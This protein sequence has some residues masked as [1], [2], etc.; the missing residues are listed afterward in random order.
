MKGE[1]GCLA[2]EAR[3]RGQ[4]PVRVSVEREVRSIKQTTTT[5]QTRSSPRAHD[6]TDR[7]RRRRLSPPN[8]TRSAGRAHARPRR[9]SKAA[10][11]K[12]RD[13]RD[14]APTRMRCD[15]GLGSCGIRRRRRQACVSSFLRGQLRSSLAWSSGGRGGAFA[16]SHDQ[17]QPK[18]T[19]SHQFDRGRPTQCVSKQPSQNKQRRARINRVDSASAGNKIDLLVA[20]SG[21]RSLVV[22]WLE[23]GCLGKPFGV[24]TNEQKR[25]F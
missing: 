12:A 6:G 23:A 22:G 17:S 21:G 1:S 24:G 15:G 5:S 16:P 10:P 25:S 4:G 18:A 13:A 7:P 20:G 14:H 8:R 2:L 9:P 11:A 19:T 3:A